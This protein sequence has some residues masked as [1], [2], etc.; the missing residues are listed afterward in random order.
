VHRA[1]AAESEAFKSDQHFVKQTVA[2]P[3]WQGYG[4]RKR[5]GEQGEEGC[6]RSS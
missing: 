2:E 5:K 4:E 3:A 6:E 1:L